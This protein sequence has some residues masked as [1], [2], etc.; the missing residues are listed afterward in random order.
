MDY[1]PS[2][3][4]LRDEG[5]F[6]FNPY[7]VTLGGIENKHY[8]NHADLMMEMVRQRVTQDFQVVTEAAV[9]E[10]ENRPEQ[11]RM[12]KFSDLNQVVVFQ[13]RH[14]IVSHIVV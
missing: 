6:Q 1:F 10:S 5:T 11:P 7:T 4:E 12:G 8:S 2:P 3:Q 13:A 14:T 9:R